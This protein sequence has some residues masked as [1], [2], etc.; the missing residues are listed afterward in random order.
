MTT[1]LQ[2]PAPTIGRLVIYRSR[3]GNYSC[4]A[5][6]TATTETLWPEGVERGDVPAL[7][8]PQHVHLHVLTPGEQGSYQE[9]NVPF[10]QQV[11]DVETAGTGPH[12]FDPKAEQAAGTWAWPQLKMA[13]GVLG[14]RLRPGSPLK[15]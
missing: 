15:A 7:D 6:V 3:T 8:G 10:W 13:S 5:I 1:Q 12:T 2:V 14:S 9:H 4:P 11:P